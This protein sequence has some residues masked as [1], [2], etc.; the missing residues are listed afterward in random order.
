LEEP[1]LLALNVIDKGFVKNDIDVAQALMGNDIV[2]F[3]ENESYL[4]R[5]DKGF[6]GVQH[7]K[8]YTRVSGI[9]S[10]NN[11]TPFTVDRCEVTLWHNPFAEFPISTSDMPLRQ[12]VLRN[13]EI[14]FFDTIDSQK[15]S[16][17]LLSKIL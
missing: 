9:L 14:P 10:V 8:K 3:I 2:R 16:F 5:N 7:N 13:P 4:W 17:D 11:L 12:K 15:S 6:W 1:F